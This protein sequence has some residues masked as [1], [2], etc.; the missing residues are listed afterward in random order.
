[1]V[2]LGPNILYSTPSYARR[3]AHSCTFLA[4]RSLHADQYAVERYDVSDFIF[5]H[6]SPTW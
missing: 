3:T 2:D 6:C 1:M 5:E 4:G